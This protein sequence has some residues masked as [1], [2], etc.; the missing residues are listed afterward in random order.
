MTTNR[1]KLNKM[2]NEELARFFDKM[3]S[4]ER[5]PISKRCHNNISCFGDFLNWLE[6]ETDMITNE[7][8][9]LYYEIKNNDLGCHYQIYEYTPIAKHKHIIMS[10]SDQK[11]CGFSTTYVENKIGEILEDLKIGID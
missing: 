5:C 9:G 10:G 11:H 8:K 2:T 7:Y 6:E 3:A 4:C 1:E